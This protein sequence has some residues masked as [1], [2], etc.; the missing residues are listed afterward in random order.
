LILRFQGAAQIDHQGTEN[1]LTGS[2]FG[3][4][5]ARAQ[6]FISSSRICDLLARQFWN[7]MGIDLPNTRL[8]SGSGRRKTPKSQD[9]YLLLLVRVCGNALL[10]YR[11][12]TYSLALQISWPKNYQQSQ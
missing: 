7:S 6:I 2:D 4:Q 8:R 5:T 9:P 11:Q 1:L 3:E 10:Y 12:S